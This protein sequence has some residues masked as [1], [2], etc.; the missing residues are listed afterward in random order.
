MSPITSE[1]P[2]RRKFVG[3]TQGMMG[4]CAVLFDADGPI[5]TGLAYYPTPDGAHMEA[6]E[7]AEA[8]GLEYDPS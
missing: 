4:W 1:K 7:W 5:L 8:E 6:A 3:V 2:T